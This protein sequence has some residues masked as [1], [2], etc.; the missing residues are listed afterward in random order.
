MSSPTPVMAP[1]SRRSFAGPVVLIALGVIF[2]LGNMHVITWR[3]LGEWFARY[4]PV[5]II[6]WGVIKLLE[7]YQAQRQATRPSGI[8]VGGVFLLLFLILTGLIATHASHVDWRALGD[9][10]DIGD[11]HFPWAGGNSYN[12]DDQLEQTFPVGGTLRVVSDRGAVTVNPSDEPQIRVVVHKRISADNEQESKKIDS[13][14]RPTISV[15]GNLVTVNANTTGAGEHSVST[16]LEI[17]IPRKAPVDIASKH[18]DVTVHERDGELKVAVTH[19]DVAI[20]ELGSRAAVVI[21]KGSINASKI[22]A[23]LTVD[24]RVDDATIADIA[25]SV[26]M[27]GDYFGDINLS[28]IAKAVN[29]KSSRTEM[30]FAR[31]DGELTMQSGDLHAKSV[32]GPLRLMTKSKDVNLEGVSGD[33]RLEDSN[34]SVQ[35]HADKLPLGN[36][37]IINTKGDVQVMLP[38]NASFSI[39]ARTHSGDIESDFSQVQ[40]NSSGNQTTATGAVGTNGVR[41][42][43]VNDYGSIEIRKAG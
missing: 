28:K 22:R 27:T 4:W 39:D 11:S 38:A 29:F 20:S 18:G 34:G 21:H 37:R 12:F 30:G 16:D 6:V 3:S 17:F 33:I 43:I 42:E 8:G 2:L 24:G 41:V 14:T 31:L 40:V 15:A 5:L 13:Q 19:G 9:E 7:Y 25:G 32:A 35:L 36:I 1:R 23:D 26:S 10:V